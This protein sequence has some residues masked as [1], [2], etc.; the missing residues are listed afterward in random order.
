VIAIDNT[1][2]ISRSTFDLQAV[3]DTLV[4]SAARLCAADTGGIQLPEGDVYRMRA[5]TRKAVQYALL[6]P[7][8]PDRG[9]VTGRQRNLLV[10]NYANRWSSRP[11]PPT[12]SR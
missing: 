11:P 7:L 9:S 2:L 5:H 8:R 4:V 1:R 12:C 6:Q 10:A 3:L